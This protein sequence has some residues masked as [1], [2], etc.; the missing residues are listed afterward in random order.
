LAV[1]L[2]KTQWTAPL[3]NLD[4]P[5]LPEKLAELLAVDMQGTQVLLKLSV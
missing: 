5:T 2:R 1:K 4:H 3:T